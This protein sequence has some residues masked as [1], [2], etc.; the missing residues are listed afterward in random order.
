MLA[1]AADESSFMMLLDRELE[2]ARRH[3]GAFG[4]TR[5]V[6]D[7]AASDP[8]LAARVVEQIRACDAAMFVDDQLV[9][10][11]SESLPVEVEPAIRRVLCA[12]RGA[13]ALA[14]S[15]AFPSNALTRASLLG[16]LFGPPIV[17]RAQV[18]VAEVP[19]S[20]IADTD[21]GIAS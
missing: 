20:V 19:A 6:V 18:H 12:G 3:G 9:V 14:N 21:A 5:F 16:Q 7:H 11:W 15:V 2:R 1:V 4:L 17:V 10:L 8:L 13:V